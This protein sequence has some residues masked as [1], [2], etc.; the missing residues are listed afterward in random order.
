[1][2]YD[3][4]FI[5]DMF[6]D[7]IILKVKGGK[8]GNGCRSFCR[9]R[10][11]PRGGPDGGNGGKGG[12]VIILTDPNLVGLN[13]LKGQSIVKGKTAGDG[14]SNNKMGFDGDDVSITVPPGTDIY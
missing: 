1:M 7:K 8:G 6:V 12:D 13:H 11:N 5:I 2:F 4:R 14:G 3:L 10:R 9:T